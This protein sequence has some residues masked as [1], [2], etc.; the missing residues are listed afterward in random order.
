[1]WLKP[2]NRCL[3]KVAKGLRSI[4]VGMDDDKICPPVAAGPQNSLRAALCW[5]VVNHPALAALAN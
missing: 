3:K 1:M 5:P 2:E 4:S